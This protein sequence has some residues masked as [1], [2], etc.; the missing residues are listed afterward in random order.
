LTTLKQ[1]LPI[2]FSSGEYNNAPAYKFKDI[3]ILLE[4]D[5]RDVPWPGK[6][7]NVTFWWKLKNG[8]AVGFN[9]NPARGWSFPVVQIK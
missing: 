5:S 7:K 9:E 4:Y 3:E 8:Y 1:R 2:E 6:H